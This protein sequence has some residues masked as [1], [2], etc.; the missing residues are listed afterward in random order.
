V[1]A[2]L[3]AYSVVDPSR[4]Y[5]VSHDGVVGG[6]GRAFVHLSYPVAVAAIALVLLAVAGL[7]RRGWWLAAPA[8]A[9]CAY[10]AWPGVVDQDDLDA[11]PANVIPA[12]GVV[13]ALALTIAAARRSGS[14][15]AP[16][17]EGD[18][19]R[20]GVAAATILIALPWIAAELGFHFPPWLF[21]TDEPYRE[22]GQPV[23]AAVH[24]G[25]HHG[26]AGTLF[27]LGALLLSRPS[28]AG[29][30]LGIAYGFL[31]SLMAVYGATNLAQ[32]FWHE[33][34]VKRGWTKWDI[35][36]ATE[37]RLHAIWL[38]MLAG[39]AAAFALGFARGDTAPASGDNHAR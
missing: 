12:M 21:L 33:Q 14:R 29:R 6:L 35:P 16:R 5:H 36:T 28:V 13:L 20:I 4:L 7:P 31:V 1:L 32:D 37:P 39:A 11:K 22:P 38:L 17:R 15:F 25:H 19:V 8:L 2:V 34:V 9:L 24:L 18:H 27:L 30:K 23:T 10:V 26:F 3:V